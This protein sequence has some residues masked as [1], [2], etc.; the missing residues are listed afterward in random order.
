MPPKRAIPPNRKER[1]TTKF[2]L[3]PNR[4]IPVEPMPVPANI[5]RQL[6]LAAFRWRIKLRYVRQRWLWPKRA[7]NR[8]KQTSEEALAPGD[9]MFFCLASATGIALQLLPNR[10]PV[11]IIIALA[12]MGLFL[13][14]PIH[15][16]GWVRNAPSGKARRVR[17]LLLFFVTVIVVI[18]YGRTIWPVGHRHIL[19]QKERALFESPLQG[20]QKPPM[21]IQISCPSSDEPTCV[22]ATQFQRYFSEVGWDVDGTVQRV[23]LMRPMQGVVLV[24]HGGTEESQTTKWKWNVGGWT[25]LSPTYENVYQAFSRIG[26]EPEG[27]ANYALPENQITVYFGPARENE[28]EPTTLT[29]TV[30][31]LRQQRAAGLVP[32]PGEL[33][34]PEM[35]K[36]AREQ[37]K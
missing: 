29:G 35:I 20:V 30:A 16:L 13:L 5:K 23:T 17:L 25:E 32:A 27:S 12:L 2:G 33:P 9:W 18:V 4:R 28:S 36:K 11:A 3:R 31:T 6:F 7:A 1:R 37:N 24:E 15:H 34:T 14:S 26:V 21:R 10:N 19:T 8:G 22:Y